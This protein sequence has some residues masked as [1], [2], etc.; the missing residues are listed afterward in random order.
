MFELVESEDMIRFKSQ[1]W[2]SNEKNAQY[3]VTSYLMG[4]R[5]K[6][7]TADLYNKG[8]LVV[9]DTPNQNATITLT[10]MLNDQIFN[11]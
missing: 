2:A 11:K 4:V 7:F 8:R 10:K 6:M 9:L 3:I 1:Y 5:E